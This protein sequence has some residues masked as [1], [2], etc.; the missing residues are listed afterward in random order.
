MAH[1]LAT[2]AGGCFWCMVEPFEEK[3]GIISVISGYSGGWKENPTYKEVCSGT[4]GHY[5][6]VQITYDPELISYETLLDIYWKS[7]DPTDEGGQFNDRGQSYQTAIFYHT[8]EQR[9]AAEK[10]KKHLEEHSP[11]NK[12]IVTKI[13]P[14]KPFYPAEEYHQNF[15]KK[16]PFRYAL[17][18]KGSGREDYL[19]KHWEDQK[20]KEELKKR[21]TPM[22]YEV[23]QNNGTEPPF[24]NEYW[25]HF[26]EGIY[27][28]VVTG[29]P[30]F[31]SKDK[32]DSGCGW[33]SF[34][35][36]I[37]KGAIEEKI[38]LSHGMVRT[39]VRSKD[40][41]SHLGHVFNDGPKELGGL[42]YCI[43]SA[44]LRFIPKEKMEEE[45]YGDYLILFK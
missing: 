22:Q 29:Y 41:D 25:D 45:G 27:V 20:K 1:Q 7:I 34:S 8:E 16:N 38:D 3:P 35:K 31:S 40:S 9:I 39:E 10:S 42:R 36:P 43:N 12:P 30:L 32:F 4:T 33:P 17:Y 2:F 21:L 44:A 26:E 11:F 19:K 18:K 24:Q 6:V 13:L 15:H 23:T 5:E 37:L 14:A 28:D